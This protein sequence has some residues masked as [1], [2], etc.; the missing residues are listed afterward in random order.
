MP[1]QL[2]NGSGDKNSYG[3]MRSYW[4]NNPDPG[5]PRRCPLLPVLLI[6]FFFLSLPLSFQSFPTLYLFILSLHS[7]ISLF[8]T[9]VFSISASFRFPSVPTEITRHLFDVCGVESVAKKIPN[10]GKHLD[11]LNSA[12]SPLDDEAQRA[13]NNFNLL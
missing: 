1:K 6:F 5:E 10:C 3:Y 2:N 9:L 8:L 11:V 12:V 7:V 13:H 4:N